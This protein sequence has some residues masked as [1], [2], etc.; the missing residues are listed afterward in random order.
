MVVAY[1]GG[2]DSALLAYAAHQALGDRMVAVLGLS[3][4][5]G[6]TPRRRAEDF[7]RRH[8]IPYTVV[9]TRELEKEAYRRNHP[10]RC[11]HCKQ[12][13]FDR[14]KE[15]ARERGFER[16]AYGANRD[17]LGDF[18]PGHRAAEQQGVW[19]PFVELGIGKAAIRAMARGLGLEVWNEPAS[20]CLA[21]RI[22]YYETIDPEKL[23][24]VDRAER[25]LLELGFRVCRVRHHGA[26]A[27]IEVPLEDRLRL[28]DPRVWPEVV[29]GIREAGFEF[30]TMDLEGFRTGRLN[31]ALRAGKGEED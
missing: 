9:E 11:Y 20:P 29:R 13:L 10:D 2:V 5:V 7:V 21:S 22:P 24:Q 14:L 17:D 31:E 26:V 1:S 12:E 15:V 30:V 6:E 25:V 27:R 3:P 28:L 4:S 18:R 8:G 23:A 19:A 16:V